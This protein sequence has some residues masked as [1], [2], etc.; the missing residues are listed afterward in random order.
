MFCVINIGMAENS[1]K[2]YTPVAST[3]KH[4]H[5]ALLD[6]INYIDTIKKLP[7][8]IDFDT[9]NEIFKI[10]LNFVDTDEEI[11]SVYQ[12]WTRFILRFAEDPFKVDLKNL[13]PERIRTA[14]NVSLK[15]SKI[16]EI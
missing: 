1:I 14:N 15:I 16:I 6:L 3:S 12:K 4:A 2:S 11:N 13:L 7:N 8:K 5:P 10:T 9:I